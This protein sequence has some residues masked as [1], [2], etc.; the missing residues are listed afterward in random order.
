M[1]C[2]NKHNHW[3]QCLAKKIIVLTGL[4]F[5]TNETILAQHWIIFFAYPRRKDVPGY[6]D[7]KAG[8]AYVSFVSRDNT[9]KQTVVDE[10]W[11]FHQW[12]ARKVGFKATQDL[13]TANPNQKILWLPTTTS[14]LR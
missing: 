3:M 8:H 5:F 12:K 14:L 6:D 11:G 9:L 7:S 1:S 4:V 13:K 10:V 2:L